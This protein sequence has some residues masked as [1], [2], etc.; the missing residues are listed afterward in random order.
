M[1]KE[2]KKKEEQKSYKSSRPREPRKRKSGMGG[3]RNR[4]SSRV[5]LD[6]SR[7]VPAAAAIA[8][9]A[10]YTQGA[11]AACARGGGAQAALGD[12]SRCTA[13]GMGTSP[14]E[15]PGLVGPV[16]GNAGPPGPAVPAGRT[17]ALAGRIW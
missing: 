7:G 9:C 16:V 10:R 12:E 15:M 1:R 11:I 8:R 6:P 14:K 5:R 2:K 4:P 17:T 3:S 13:V